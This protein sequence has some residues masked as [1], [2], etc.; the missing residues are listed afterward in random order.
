MTSRQ[1]P[2]SVLDLASVGTGTS[3]GQALHDSVELA[4]Q[5]E[6]LGYHRFWVAEHHGMPGIASSAPAILIGQAAAATE[7]IRVGSGGVMLPNHPPLVVAE[8]FGTLEAMF[9]GRID[10]GIGRAPGT[11]PHTARALRRSTGPLSADDFPR[12]LS[13]LVAFFRGDFP[14]GHPYR[15]VVPVPGQ[16]YEPAIWLLGS[17]GYSAQVAGLLGLPFAF[18]HHFSA[19]NTLPALDLYR[20]N[21]RPSPEL[22]EPYAMIAVS[23]VAADTDER[24]R[25]IARSGELSFLHLRRGAPTTVPTPEEAAAYP[26]S[27]ME[28]AIMDD[29]RAEQAVGSPETVRRRLAE[30]L[31]ETQVD[32]LMVTNIIHAHADRVRSLEIVRQVFASESVPLDR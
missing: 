16:G 30:L 1:I 12:Q 8:Q 26:Y 18:A 25:Y 21:F 14:E 4:R 10:L 22:A 9:N 28:L 7:T 5:A 6:R 2:L 29:R 31:E 3:P 11:D 15:S 24:A 20:E 27:E 32:E 17:S 13:E 23:V 19:E